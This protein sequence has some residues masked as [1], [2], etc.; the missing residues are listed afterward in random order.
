[1]SNPFIILK[2]AIKM[3]LAK[4]IYFEIKKLWGQEYYDIITNEKHI[5][6]LFT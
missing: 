5:D 2:K 4:F 6:K 3:N 1:M